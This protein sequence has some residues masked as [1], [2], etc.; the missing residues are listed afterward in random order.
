MKNLTQK[1]FAT[2][3]PS[4]AII[5]ATTTKK[6]AAKKLNTNTKNIYQYN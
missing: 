6:I 2:M 3:S 1:K 4:G 5:V